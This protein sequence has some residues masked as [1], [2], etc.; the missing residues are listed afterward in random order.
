ML[1]WNW[2]MLKLIY[3]IKKII[4]FCLLSAFL[5]GCSQSN[6]I[7]EPQTTINEKTMQ[8]V[9]E[10]EEKKLSELYDWDKA[11]ILLDWN[12]PNFGYG[13]IQ[14]NKY[15][16]FYPDDGNKIVRINKSD[17]EK[18]VIY[19]SKFNKELDLHY[20]LADDRLYIE[21]FGNIYSCDFEG[22]NTSKIISRKKLKRQVVAIKGN[23]WRTG[24]AECL[25]FY[26]NDLYFISYFYMWKLDL[27]TKKVSK[28]SKYAT[29]GGC[30]CDN[31]LFYT[32]F[33]RRGAFKTDISTG[34]STPVLRTNK[35]SDNPKY[36]EGITESDGKIYYIQL[37]T[38]KKP[39]LYM[40]RD[41]KDD[42]KICDF[43]VPSAAVCSV[44]CDSGKII[45]ECGPFEDSDYIVITYDVKSAST[46][47]IEM[48]K[49]FY[50]AVYAPDDML[51]Y[52]VDGKN[53]EYLSYL[54]YD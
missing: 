2:R 3:N 39:V 8:L 15:Y 18:K 30:F 51:F 37:Q 47:K 6:S 54:C 38:V 48:P 14:Q 11:K 22:N 29:F 34:K 24:G 44:K 36:Y 21:D 49:N 41:G 13:L 28:I 19:N 42:K 20:C 1:Y 32:D 25:Y 35:N 31:A 27:S 7:K 17:G 45:L 40:Y 33:S 52:A 50:A 46:K 43:N 10:A 16:V 23:G 5:T 26:K 9:Q 4:I 53:D 12:Y